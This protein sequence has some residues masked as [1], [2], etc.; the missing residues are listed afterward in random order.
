MANAELLVAI[1][2]NVTV[3]F[4][5]YS[6]G[7]PAYILRNTPDLLSTLSTRQTKN[8]KQGA[9]GV[10]DSLTFYDDRPLP[11][12]GEIVGTSQADRKTKEEALKQCLALSSFQSYAGNDGNILLKFTDEDGALKQCYAK[13]VTPPK[14]G[15]IDNTD[16]M[17]RSFGFVMMAKDPNLYGQTL[18]SGSGTETYAGTN[19]QVVQS[20]APSVPFQLYQNTVASVTCVNS[21]TKDAP[22][23]I[24]VTGPS[25]GPIVKNLTTSISMDLSGSGGLVLA[26]GEKVVIDFNAFSITKYDVSNVATNASGYLTAASNWI[27]LQAGS[28]QIALFDG[29]PGSLLAT[30]Q[31]QWRNTY[32]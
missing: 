10:V 3:T 11:F 22:P 21:G 17:R 13:I 20:S 7:T 5:D 26:A 29:T 31:V 24:T 14:F 12:V 30:I 32:I 9:H 25:T 23:V 1:V 16:P 8:P 18:Q 27:L 19:F 2:G 15:V 28:N 6:G 4:N